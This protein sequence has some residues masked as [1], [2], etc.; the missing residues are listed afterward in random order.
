MMRASRVETRFAAAMG[1]RLTPLVNREEEIALLMGRWQQAK[2]GEGQVVVKFGEPGIGKSRIIQEIFDRIAGDRH[3]QVSFQCSP[4]Y[5][6]TAFYPFAE[7]LKFSLGLDR[8][9]ASVQSLASLETAIAAAHG[10]I[11]QVAPL[12]AV[13]LSIPTGDRYPPLELSPQQQKDATVAALVNHFLGLAREQPLVIAFEDLHWIDPTSREVIDLLVD[14]AQNRAILVIITARTEFQPSWNAHSHITTLVL[15]RLSRQLRATLVERVAGRELPKE[16]IEEII[17][18]TD[19]VPL[20]LE[21]LTKTVL[22]SNLLTERHGRYVLSGPW[23][24]LAIPATLTDSLMAR[25]DRM[26]PFKRIAQIGATIGP[27]IL[28][29]DSARGRQHTRR[30]DRGRAQSFGGGRTDHAP[31]PSARRALLLQARDD[32]ERRACELAAQRAAQAAFPDRPGA[33]RDVS[34]EDRART[35]TARPSYDRIRPERERRQLLA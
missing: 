9:D 14:R 18:K 24:Q 11:E 30:T 10:D 26:G 31:R 29:R 19:G 5:T 35:G 21:E 16:V 6:S 34:R 25:L 27:R 2:E 1:T 13:L 7:Q 15:N 4:Y 20:F 22:E 23:R 8:E 17:V 12:F 33:G 3:G 28:L 32:S